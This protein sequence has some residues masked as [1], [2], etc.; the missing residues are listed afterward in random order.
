MGVAALKRRVHEPLADRDTGA[1]RRELM[2][3][4]DELWWSHPLGPPPSAFQV[5]RHLHEHADGFT[6]FY[7]VVTLRSEVNI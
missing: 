1:K 3:A 4:R 5:E 7:A 6:S 2:P